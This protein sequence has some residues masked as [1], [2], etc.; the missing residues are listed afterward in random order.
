MDPLFNLAAWSL[1]WP[2]TPSAIA[3]GL[4]LGFWLQ[5]RRGASYG[6]ALFSLTLALLFVAEGRGDLLAVFAMLVSVLLTK[7]CVQARPSLMLSGLLALVFLLLAER[8][9]RL[10][11]VGYPEIEE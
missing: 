8:S 9:Q 1:A 11:V 2:G 7:H 10:G 4:S 3:L 6:T 5:G